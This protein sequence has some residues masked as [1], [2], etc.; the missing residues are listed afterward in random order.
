MFVFTN[1]PAISSV[2]QA[3]ESRSPGERSIIPTGDAGYGGGLTFIVILSSTTTLLYLVVGSPKQAFNTAFKGI[4]D[5]R[6]Q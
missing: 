6:N 5:F 2:D 3:N 1:I 4:R